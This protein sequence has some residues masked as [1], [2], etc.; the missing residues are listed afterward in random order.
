MYSCVLAVNY[1]LY[2]YVFRVFV[3]LKEMSGVRTEALA[4]IRGV[5]ED[6]AGAR[7]KNVSQ[8]YDPRNRFQ[9]FAPKLGITRLVRLCGSQKYIKSIK[10]IKY[11][12]I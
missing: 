3:K 12:K 5:K 1:C 6:I 10:Y 8:M 2:I 11:L 4:L 7:T 9:V